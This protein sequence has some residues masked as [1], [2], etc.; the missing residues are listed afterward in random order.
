MFFFFF[1]NGRAV[2]GVAAVVMVDGINLGSATLLE[3]DVFSFLRT[4]RD[5]GHDEFRK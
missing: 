3:Y 4:W 5:G 2:D 1:R